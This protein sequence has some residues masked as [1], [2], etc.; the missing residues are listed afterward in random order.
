MKKI[1]EEIIIAKDAVK[2][3]RVPKFENER[4]KIEIE[5]RKA[6]KIYFDEK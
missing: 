5:N 2:I 1:Q 4:F 3:K 6:E